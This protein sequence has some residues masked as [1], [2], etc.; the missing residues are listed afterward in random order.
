MDKKSETARHQVGAGI[1]CGKSG[2]GAFSER[3][4]NNSEGGLSA[5][6]HQRGTSLFIPIFSGIIVVLAYDTADE[7]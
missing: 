4:N 6:A 2:S 7:T 3:Q 1:P 5:V